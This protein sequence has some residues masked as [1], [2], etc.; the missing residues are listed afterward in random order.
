MLATNYFIDQKT[1][2]LH[3]SLELMSPSSM[4][5]RKKSTDAPGDAILSCIFFYSDPFTRTSNVNDFSE[6][7]RL[8]SGQVCP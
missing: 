7:T 8:T 1:C 6:D 2:N 5:S 4:H 3:V